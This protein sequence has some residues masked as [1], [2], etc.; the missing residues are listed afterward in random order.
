MEE[1]KK[2]GYEMDMCSGPIVGKMLVFALPLMCSSLLQLLFNAA[3]IIVVGNC[4]GD[5]SM[6][7]VG[8]N[9]ALISLMTNV[10]IGLSV[11]ANVMVSHYYGA[12][13]QEALSRTVHTAMLLSV[14]S[15]LL[16]TGIGSLGARQMLVWMK[17]PEAVLDLAAL[18]LR[19][20]FFGMPA[21]MIYN[22]GSAILRSVGDT[23]RPLY[24]LSIAG[25]INVAL[26]LLFVIA[27]EMDV[28]GVA[29]ATVISQCVSAAL[30]VRC[31][32][33]AQGG[34]GIEWSKLAIDS[35]KLL[36]IMRIG[37]PAGFQ[38]VIF[39]LSNV[40]IQS[41]VNSFDEIVMAGNTAA[42]N[43]EGFVY[44]AMNA[45]HQTAIS[46][47]SQ[48]MGAGR[49][50]R[51]RRI[52]R[53]G[54]LCVF[55]VG[56]VLGGGMVLA[57]VPLLHIYSKDPQVIA[58][59]MNRIMIIGTTYYLCGMMDVMVGVLR[60]M[61]YSVMPTVVSLLGACALRL[62]WIATIFQIAQ[63]HTIKTIYLS[64]PITWA[65]TLLAHVVCYCI[66]CRRKS[67]QMQER[68]NNIG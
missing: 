46:F 48:N 47:T 26:N 41:S 1:N 64:Y 38:G 13:Q 19:I 50:D 43:I 42:A 23:R 49:L 5:N 21:M 16:L 52:A 27:L 59:G 20:Y 67:R 10:F 68:I 25:A 35:D 36:R 40:V 22:F 32:L 14:I 37:I 30:V 53:N 17:T 55:V 11:G 29:L 62:V 31:M 2:K 39:S 51:I 6:A 44:V 57:G 65:V 63:F 61:G 28:A 34:I 24:F 56:A 60:G 12:K 18:Y 58:A 54:E 9:T 66:V 3:D 45:F 7:A 8:S 33:R 15:G 4:A